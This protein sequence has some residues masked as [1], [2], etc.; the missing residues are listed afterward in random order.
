MCQRV[1]IEEIGGVMV[2][3]SV[4]WPLC[5]LSCVLPGSAWFMWQA[6]GN[7]VWPDTL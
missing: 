6:V 2:R 4:T 1:A 7:T 3:L 5:G